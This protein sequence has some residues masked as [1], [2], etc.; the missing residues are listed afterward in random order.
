MQG[1]EALESSD[2]QLAG[3]DVQGQ[4]TVGEFRR[5]RPGST[6]LPSPCLPSVWAGSR[7]M[8]TPNSNGKRPGAVRPVGGQGMG[9]FM[10][11]EWTSPGC[12]TAGRPRT[13]TSAVPT[14]QTPLAP[15]SLPPC[16]QHSC[17]S[18]LGRHLNREPGPPT[19]MRE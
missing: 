19:P 18:L 9:S 15:D 6:H 8:A 3:E 1:T 12:S 2:L 13:F 10:N 5:A 7:H 17:G 11:T 4:R 16:S 14:V